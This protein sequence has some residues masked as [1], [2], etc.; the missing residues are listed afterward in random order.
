MELFLLVIHAYFTIIDKFF[1]EVIMN[2]NSAAQ[3]SYLSQMQNNAKVQSQSSASGKVPNQGQYGSLMQQIDSSLMTMLDTNQNGSIDKAE[4]SD[5]AKQ[6]SQGKS[7]SSNTDKAFAK[8]DTNKD[9]TITADELMSMLEQLS[10][11]NKAKKMSE[12]LEQSVNN[13]PT[14]INNQAS[15]KNNMQSVLMK[16]ILSA[17]SSNYVASNTSGVNLKA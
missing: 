3:S 12:R 2:V 5:M 11:K 4:F 8:I 9:G 15:D 16:N 17:Y 10:T 14:Q 6:L 13:Q 7:V 1:K